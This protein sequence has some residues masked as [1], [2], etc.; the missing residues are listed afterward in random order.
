MRLSTRD[1]GMSKPKSSV[2]HAVLSVLQDCIEANVPVK[3][4]PTF[5]YADNIKVGST[6]F[7]ALLTCWCVVSVCLM[8]IKSASAH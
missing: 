8:M 2:L 5:P 4:F 6:A 3:Q 1:A 7:V